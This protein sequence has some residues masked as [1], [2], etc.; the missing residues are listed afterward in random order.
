MGT[1]NPSYAN[2]FESAFWRP[3]P[4]IYFPY[5]LLNIC[6]RLWSESCLLQSC[7]RVFMGTHLVIHSI[8]R[9]A[10]LACWSLLVFCDSRSLHLTRTER[11]IKC[12]SNLFNEGHIMRV[13]ASW[14]S[15]QLNLCDKSV[16]NRVSVALL[17]YTCLKQLSS[18][19]CNLGK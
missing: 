17:N 1:A 6:G 10:Y 13:P 4:I 3:L 16:N 8:R 14:Y 12:W 5:A 2:M 18:N 11:I 15:K 7:F 19:S 9:Q